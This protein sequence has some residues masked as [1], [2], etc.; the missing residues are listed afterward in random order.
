MDCDGWW[1]C[2]QPEKMAKKAQSG[3]QADL[4]SL[5]YSVYTYEWLFWPV[6]YLTCDNAKCVARRPNALRGANAMQSRYGGGAT[7]QRIFDNAN[8]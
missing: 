2:C 4:P 3:W 7:V 5:M 8:L 1:G 6:N